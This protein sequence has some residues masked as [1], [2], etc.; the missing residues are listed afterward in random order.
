MLGQARIT[1]IPTAEEEEKANFKLDSEKSFALLVITPTHVVSDDGEADYIW[2]SKTIEIKP[3]PNPYG[4]GGMWGHGGY[5]PDEEKKIIS[6][7]HHFVKPWIERGL[8]RV[9]IK[10]EPR[11][12][13]RV[14]TE[15]QRQAY[16]NR[17]RNQ[18]TSQQR[19]G[20]RVMPE[21]TALF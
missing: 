4:F 18:P 13:R 9:E 3:Y 12:T 1:G 5:Q 14:P 11:E 16:L 10:H 15:A 20:S 19:A 7:F 6:D 2:I 17:V 8:T 21:Q